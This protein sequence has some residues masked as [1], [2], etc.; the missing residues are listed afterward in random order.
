[1]FKHSVFDSIL[2]FLGIGQAILWWFSISNF[3]SLST[4]QIIACAVS[5]IVL[6]CT[7]YQ[8]ISHNFIHNEFF[9]WP[10]LNIVFSIFNSIALGMPQSVYKAHHINHHAHNNDGWNE[11]IRPGDRSSLFLYG[12]NHKQESLLRYTFLSYFRL[13]LLKLFSEAYSRNGIVVILELAALFSFCTWLVFLN[14]I[15]FALFYIPVHFLGTS[16]ASMENYAEHNGCDPLD[17][18]KNSVSCYNRMYNFLWFN[19][20]FHQEH[21][22]EPE[23]H[24]RDLPNITEKLPAL[25]NRRVVSGC[26]LLGLMEK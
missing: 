11:G 19:N 9:K 18:K 7:N 20:G 8:C 17:H 3:D 4:M 23:I 26:H 21:H 12:K 15:A 16:L 25:N 13:N 6:L 2:V 1:M 10:L 5:M 22:F 24:W 14:P